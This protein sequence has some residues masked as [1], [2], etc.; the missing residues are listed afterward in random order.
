[1]ND[2]ISQLIS[3]LTLPEKA[4]LC[5]GATFWDT[6]SID[7]VHIPSFVFADGP[8][9]LRKENNDDVEN[10]ALK[11]SYPATSFPPAVN[12]AST[13][14]PE[15]IGE[16]GKALGEQCLNQG[17]NVLLGPGTNIKRSPLCGRNF[18]YFSE[19]P[20][21]A[22]VMSYSY[23]NG[24]ESTNV[25]TSLKHFAVNNQES[26][27]MTINS[28]VDER[29]LRELYLLP[30]EL[31]IKNSNPKTVMCSYNK[32]NGVYS[33]DN[34][35]LLSDILRDEWGFKGLVVSDWNAVNDRVA[36]IHAGMDIEMPSCGGRT[37]KE[38]V[39]AVVDGSLS[40]EELNTVV[41][42]ILELAFLAEESKDLEYFYNYREGHV[43]ARA[44]ADE[45]IILLKN[46]DRLLPLN[47][48][49]D[50]TVIGALADGIRYQGSGSSRINPYKLISLIDHLEQKKHSYTYAPGYKFSNDGFD[51]SLLDE[52]VELAKNKSNVVL[53]VGLTDSY[54]CEGYDRT[55]LSI[56]TSHTK[57]IESV[58]EVNPNV[59][60]IVLGG[61]PIEMP[62]LDKVKAVI[63]AYLPGEAAGEAIADVLFG[64]TNPSGKL[65]ETYPIALSDFIGSQYYK[66]G[67]KTTEHRESMF[68]GY[69][70][71]DTVEKNV[72]F[73]FGYGLSYT[74]FE[75]S[76][77]KLSSESIKDTETL[78]VTFDITNTGDVFGAEVAQLYVHDVDSVAFRPYKEL[79]GFKKVFLAPNET[80]TVSL[81]LDKRSFA[82]YNTNIN[83]WHVESG[84]FDILI[85]ASSREILLQDTVEVIDTMDNVPLLNMREF[86]PE[87]YNLKDAETISADSFKAIYGNDLPANTITKRGDFDKNSTVGDLKCCIP[88]KVF[89]KVAPAVIRSSVP[90]ADLTTMLMMQQGM[91]EMPVRALNGVTSG[92]LDDIVC[93]GMLLWANKH[94]M[95]GLFRMIKGFII[96]IKNLLHTKSESRVSLEKRKL[97]E[98]QNTLLKM[99]NEA[100]AKQKIAIE[101]LTHDMNELEKLEGNDTIIKK[102]IDNHLKHIES[103]KAEIEL[104]K[105]IRKETVATYKSKIKEDIENVRVEEKEIKEAMKAYINSFDNSMITDSQRS[106]LL[107]TI[108]DKIRKNNRNNNKTKSE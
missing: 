101:N 89:C 47:I 105:S 62:W 37:D 4:S 59:T 5:S 57:L 23:I 27:R 52:A 29:A 42:R 78:E 100:I 92:L 44:V 50:L 58:A 11:S 19:D 38:I 34:K 74:T 25:G 51:Q 80:A 64:K 61:S 53:V 65:A 1:M 14:N 75:Y 94:R 88:G 72:L 81:K 9:G 87:Y 6:K 79:K 71:Y 66:G 99:Q 84:K 70:Y 95:K 7:R 73:P 60:I 103:I 93:E 3:E 107:D 76:N 49:D 2:K 97:K 82:Y 33:S 10:V 85:G 86:A 13:W 36:G 91:E 20:Y 104:L 55:N 56:P 83:D 35:R 32:I 68:V 31:A 15:L 18:E 8:H 22:G 28:V 67:P 24:V 69:R 41:R 45:S 46:N 90:D 98:E 26:K 12:M 54:E 16:V 102:H 30:F 21:L 106:K 39:K 43:L 63:N 96:S 17:V 48:E 40:E 77:L 108:S